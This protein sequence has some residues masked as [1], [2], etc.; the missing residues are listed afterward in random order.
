MNKT[1]LIK[2]VSKQSNFSQNNCKLCL[3]ALQDVLTQA[4]LR[5]EVIN[6]NGF[7]KFFAKY[8]SQR[9]GTNPITKDTIKIPSKYVPVFCSSKAFRAKFN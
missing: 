7:G 9:I 1:E 3:Q 8:K 2:S 4:L 5:G 6:L